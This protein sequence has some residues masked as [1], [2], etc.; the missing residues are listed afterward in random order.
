[1]TS[2][3]Q[4]DSTGSRACDCGAQPEPE[5]RRSQ[6]RRIRSSVARIELSQRRLTIPMRRASVVIEV[7]IET[8]TSQPNRD[9]IGVE[10][11][12]RVLLTPVAD[13]GG[14]QLR[15]CTLACSKACP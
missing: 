11:T 3:D 10:H 2:V 5:R 9:S 12:L 1:M 14:P 8:N 4:W 15:S 6:L 7:V 13:G